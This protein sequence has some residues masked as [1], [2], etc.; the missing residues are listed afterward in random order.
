MASTNKTTHY[1]LSQYIGSDKPTYLVD[2]NMDMYNIDN[3]IYNAQSKADVN[4]GSIG[5][6]SSLTTTEKSNLVGAINEIDAQ[7]GTN[8]SNIATN[9]L[10]ISTNSTAIGDLTNLTTTAK[11]DLVSA[12]NEVQS[13]TDT[14]TS[15]IGLLSNLIT[16]DKTNV[17]SAVNEVDGVASTNSTNIGDLTTL[18][19]TNKTNLVSAVNEVNS[20]GLNGVIVWENPSPTATTFGAQTVNLNQDITEFNVFDIFYTNEGNYVTRTYDK[21]IQITTLAQGRGNS[22]V[23][24][25][26][27]QI[28]SNN[29]V[30]FSNAIV[31]G[32]GNQNG[33]LIPQ[34]IIAYKI[35]IS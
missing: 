32:S 11:S 13:E 1:E 15:N 7:V 31:P 23:V 24:N 27:A 30:E 17:V 5:T 21:G 16:T 9:T 28:N 33:Y 2:Y 4:E 8:T 14:N 12:V 18:T 19:T 3:G 35:N 10:D 6:L 22:R 20:K 29:T 34:K 25:R 26:W